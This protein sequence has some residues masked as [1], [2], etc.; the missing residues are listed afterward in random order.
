MLGSQPLGGVR[1][2]FHP[3]VWDRQAKGKVL[4]NKRWAEAQG[5]QRARKNPGVR[6]AGRASGCLQNAETNPTCLRWYQQT[7]GTGSSLPA[8][9]TGTRVSIRNGRKST[10]VSLGIIY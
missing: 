9:P 5:E 2:I 3:A 4:N 1:G 6:E 7:V 8:D 10:A